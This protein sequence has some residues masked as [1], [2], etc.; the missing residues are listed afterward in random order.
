VDPKR[1]IA[2]DTLGIAQR[3]MEDFYYLHS[4]ATMG[5]TTSSNSSSDAVAMLHSL[6]EFGVYHLLDVVNLTRGHGNQYH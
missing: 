1:R 2:Q 4:N 5:T 3:V 6:G